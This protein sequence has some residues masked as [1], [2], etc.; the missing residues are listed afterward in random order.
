M[1]IAAYLL[2]AIDA[3]GPSNVLQV[4]TDNAANCKAAGKE[5]E[6]VHKHIFWSP[7][8]VHTLNLVFKDFAAAAFPWMTK[9][10][11]RGKSIVKYFLNHEKAQAIFKTQ[12]ALE[13]LKVAKTRFASHHLLLKRLSLY[14]EALATTVVLRSWKDWVNSGDEQTKALGKEVAA[15]IVSEDF[16]EELENILVITKPIYLMIK[17]AECEGV[18]MGEIYEKMDCMIGEIRDIMRNNKY[19]HVNPRMEEI[20]L[21]RWEKI[22]IPM[23]CLGFA[24]NPFY[25][26]AH[27]LNAL[28]PGGESRRAPNQDRE[29]VAGVLKFFD[30]IGEDENEKAELRR[31]L[32]TFQNK[33]GIFGTSAAKVDASMMSPI[34]WWS[35]YGAETP[36]LA[37]I[38]MKALSQPISSSSAERVWST[39]SYIHNIKRNRLNTKRAD[40]LV[41]IHS[42]IRLLSRFTSAYKEGPNRKWDVDPESTY[43][44]DSIVR[45]EDLQWK[46]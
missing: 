29:V 22:N 23:H 15:T 43:F 37:E 39:Y 41:F 36:E 32:A 31:Q 7:C 33:L 14:R 6:K 26:D 16:W 21:S 46:N 3:V 18:K 42:N 38:A 13:L 5:I 40:K 4:V 24:L 1:N 25:Y 17:F 28:A 35:T 19:S 12:S 11:M 2:E 10:Y 8:V 45:L 44:D 27:Y 9:T 30:K 20:L 34:S